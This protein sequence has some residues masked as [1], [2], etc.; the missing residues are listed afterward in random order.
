MVQIERE[1]LSPSHTIESEVKK[2]LS[3]VAERVASTKIG[4]NVLQTVDKV[5]MVIEQTAKWSLP[6][7]KGMISTIY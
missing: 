6:I 1:I 2:R 7:S 3:S 4:Q 5:L